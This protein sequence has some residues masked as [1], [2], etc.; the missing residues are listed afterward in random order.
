[1]EVGQLRVLDVIKRVGRPVREFALRLASGRRGVRR[2][3]N[4]LEYRVDSRCRHQFV[5]DYEAEV[6]MFLRHRIAPGAVIYNVGAHVGVLAVQL[7]RWSGPTGKV[8]AFEP[9]PY[10]VTLLKRNLRLNG[11]DSRVDVVDVAIGD[12]VGEVTLHISGADPMARATKPNPLLLNT[13]AVRV[14]ITTLD[15]FSENRRLMPDWVVM[16]IEGWEVA[17]LRGG[18]QL[19]STKSRQIGIVVEVHPDAWSGD[20]RADVEDIL[21]SL[22]RRPVPLGGQADPLAEHGHVYL[23][24]CANAQARA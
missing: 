24:S 2:V 19:L 12:A 4:G 7:A 13:E 9:N 14:P 23:D 5:D 6:A 18:K 8:V 22:G 20:S 10:A 21:S 16:D 15:Q 17:A 11:L 3:V 1:V